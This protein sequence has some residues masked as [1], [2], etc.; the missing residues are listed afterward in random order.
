MDIRN[1]TGYGVW[2]F[3]V[4]R[5]FFRLSEYKHQHYKTIRR[6]V[7]LR[8]LLHI[9]FIYCMWLYTMILAS[10]LSF[11]FVFHLLHPKPN[12]KQTSCIREHCFFKR[13][14][15]LYLQH[16]KIARQRE[17]NAYSGIRACE[18]VSCVVVWPVM[19]PWNLTA[20]TR[21]YITA[22][23]HTHIYSPRSS[24]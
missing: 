17:Q 10:S 12:R 22:Q 9:P 5:H 4:V 13:I 23:H 20:A 14:A 6:D 21:A 16:P 3:L 2:V 1:S 18:F 24:P 11:A 7:L 15:R 8:V 19:L